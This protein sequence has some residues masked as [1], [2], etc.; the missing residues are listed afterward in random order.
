VTAIDDPTID[1]LAETWGREVPE[2][3][4]EWL[5][6]HEPVHWHPE[7]DGR[8]FWAVTKH[9]DVQA[10]SRNTTTFSSWEGGTFIVDHEQ[11]SLDKIR[12]SILNMDPPLHSRYRRLVSKG[13]TPKVVRTMQEKAARRATTIVDD[14]IERGEVEFVEDV[15]AL[16]P[17]QMIADL[18]GIPDSE[19][20]QLF[21][22]SNRMVGFDDPELQTS[23]EDGELA[24]MEIFAYCD[25]IAAA[26]RADPR[27]DLMS[28][29]ANAEVDGERMSDIELNLFFV[30]L[31]VAGNETSRNLITHSALALIDDP[32]QA[33]LLRDDPEGVWPTAIDEMLRWGSSIHN[34][35]RTTTEDTEI[36]G[37]AIPAGDKVVMYYLSANRDEEVFVDPYRFDLRR[38]PNDHVTFGGGGEHFCLGHN[39]AKMQIRAMIDE[40]VRRMPDLETTEQPRRMRSDFINGITRA[41]MRFTPGSRVG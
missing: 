4:L 39:L 20:K 25:E 16:L 24:A 27:D 34:F 1:L 3:Q 30:T 15:A 29:L 37:Q 22:W 5:R 32:D 13:F 33:Q 12:M 21:D 8:G 11:D 26:R 35:R 9:A 41:P 38:S 6:T 23:E 7:P 14:V 17:L 19:H 36:R 10:I 31:V 18:I 28:I 2:R 40:I